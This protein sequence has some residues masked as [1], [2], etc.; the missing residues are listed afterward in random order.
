M[1]PAGFR[2]YWKAEPFQPF[3]LRLASGRSVE[4]AHPE[5]VAISPGGR[6]VAIFQPDS[7]GAAIID[8]LL[9]ESVEYPN[10]HGSNGTAD[11]GKG[12]KGG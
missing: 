7:D 6:T 9:V 11:G 3:L 4:V 10:G 8:L 1:T 5:F 12:G 2:E